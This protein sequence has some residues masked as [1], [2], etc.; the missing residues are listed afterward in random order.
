MKDVFT[1]DPAFRALVR[2]VSRGLILIGAL[3]VS[4][5]AIM[6]VKSMLR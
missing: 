1:D 6:F 4:N 5:C 3:I 2:I